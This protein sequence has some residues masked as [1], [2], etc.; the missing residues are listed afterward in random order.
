MQTLTP[1]ELEQARN[2]KGSGLNTNE[3]FN[4]IAA[5][6]TGTKTASSF[7]S[8]TPTSNLSETQQDF[9]ETIKGVGGS[10]K[11]FASNLSGAVTDPN[12]N[13]MQK[14]VASALTVP[15]LGLDIA[16]EA[17]TGVG[18]MSVGQ[19]VEDRVSDTI[20]AGVEKGLETD[21]AKGIMSWYDSQDAQSQFTTSRIIMPLAE[22]VSEG[23][24]G[25]VFGKVFNRARKASTPND[26][27]GIEQAVNDATTE[28]ANGNIA[29]AN[30]II[31]ATIDPTERQGAVDNLTKAYMSSMV[32]D[33]TAV[34]N[35][36]DDLAS[37]QSRFSDTPVTRDS[38]IA[39]LANEGY[40]P[41]PEGRR[42]RFEDSFADVNK[43][44]A[45]LMQDMEGVLSGVRETS[46][47]ADFY[48]NLRTALRSDPR[49]GSDINTALRRIDGMEEA[50]LARFGDTMT[51]NEINSL[52]IEGNQKRGDVGKTADPIDT[53]VWANQARTA[54]EWLN[55]NIQDDL[56]KRTNA[57]WA[58][59]KTLED[60]MNILRNQQ[61]DVGLLGRA[62]GSYLSVVAG[63][64][65]GL[66]VGGAGGLVVAGLLAK[67]GSDT[68]ADMIR[69]KIFNPETTQIIRD[70]MRNDDNLRVELQKTAST[71][72]NRNTL[73]DMMGDV[74]T[75]LELPP[76][77]LDAPRSEVASG[78]AIEVGGQTE[79]GQVTTGITERTRDGAIRQP[80][81][82]KEIELG[83]AK[84]ATTQTTL[85]E[86]AKGFDTADAFVKKPRG[87]EDTLYHYTN[88]DVGDTLNPRPD[89][90]LAEMNYLGDG[91]YVTNQ[92]YGY[93]GKNELMAFPSKDLD[94]L[95]LTTDKAEEKFLKQI[96]KEIGTPVARSGGGLYDDL[97]LMASNIGE[98]HQRVK[99]AVSK[100]SKGKDGIKVNFAQYTN[101]DNFYELVLNEKVGV[102]TK[103]QLTDIWKQAN[104]KPSLLE[105]AKG[106]PQEEFIAKNFI[107]N[108]PLLYKGDGISRA[109]F[110]LPEVLDNPDLFAKYPVLRDYNVKFTSGSVGTEKAGITGRSILL[111]PKLYDK[112]PDAKRIKELEKDLQPFLDKEASGTLTDAEY[113]QAVKITD[114]LSEVE[115]GRKD[116]LGVQL[117]ED[118]MRSLYHEIQHAKQGT[119]GFIIKD[120]T[121][122]LSEN[123]DLST[124]PSYWG[125]RVEIDARFAETKYKTRKELEKIWED[126]N[127]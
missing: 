75:N 113:K 36:L 111:T 68:L 98:N 107:E 2:L 27:A 125:D 63:S 28:A 40:V 124:D 15:T 105:E 74:G 119:D 22:A 10:F 29:P 47:T 92:K 46:S 127:R 49:I 25:G 73:Q 6:R 1:Q 53:D 64:S 19:G 57:E 78:R 21:F 115:S 93:E 114:N 84:S 38:L 33:R 61:I 94:I 18:K 3:I 89:V 86:E 12:A 24:G 55:G 109:S 91:V 76:A 90:E 41:V 110:K 17:I 56:F 112:L 60:T 45:A 62:L 52:K 14:G 106:L 8:Q 123:S 81:G 82:E 100:V 11:R 44:Q 50:S 34:N 65:A 122:T 51:A 67:I 54:N 37:K 99:D 72:E 20:G 83:K 79:R 48:T 35:R 85:L 104:K 23:I 4:Q 126:A 96:S 70:V 7:G 69:K 71:Q 43:R 9:G 58:R 108:K 16:G 101:D 87:N 88:A 80:D 59:L 30:R 116:A 95:D 103:A 42:A 31:N 66:A 120:R 102:K 39:N 117:N 77:T 5:S 13:I 121:D 32:E 118:G 97:R 26:R